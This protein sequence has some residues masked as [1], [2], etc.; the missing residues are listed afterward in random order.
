MHGNLKENDIL[1]SIPLTGGFTSIV[2]YAMPQTTWHD[3][4]HINASTLDFQLTDRNCIPLDL[5][6][7]LAF[8]LTFDD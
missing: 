3:T 1:C 8:Q 4:H 7:S 2:N 6:S 5:K